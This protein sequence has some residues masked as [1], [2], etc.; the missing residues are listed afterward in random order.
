MNA[1][2]P[3]SACRVFLGLRVAC[4]GVSLA[5]VALAE[6]T[7][8]D[9]SLATQLFKEGRTLVDQGKYAEGCRKLEESQ[10]LDP[11]GGTLLNLALC[12]EKEGRSATAWTEFTE[13]LG[14]ARK[15]DR[16]QRAEI[17][18]Q[19]IEALEPT[20]SRLIVQVPPASDLPDLEIKR[21][22]TGI[23]R[24][25]WGTAM[26]IDPG[27][28]IIEAFAL[29]RISWKQTVTVGGKAET[30][31]I[32][33]PIL[34]HAPVVP[35]P[36]AATGSSQMPATFVEVR[37]PVNPAAWIAYGMGAAGIAVGTYFGVRAMS[38]QK[39]ADDNCTNDG[40]RNSNGTSANSEAIKSA[41]ISTVGFGV[42]VL[43]VGLGTVLLLSRGTTTVPSTPARSGSFAP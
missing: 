32:S 9:K 42:G 6:P 30:K 13:A 4:L 12:H 15:D 23:R 3:P 19:H 27:E 28:H 34:E 36:S 18:Q 40:C 10:R 31:T 22:G 35:T 14:I 39:T 26:P 11:G 1:H 29:G 38:D 8:A 5:A 7:S 16:P 25:A 17:A 37:K 2:R 21:D 41:N 20:L 24:A 33:V 43:G